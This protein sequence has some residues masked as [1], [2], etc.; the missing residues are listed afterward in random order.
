[1]TQEPASELERLVRIR[2]LPAEPVVIEADA[3]ERERLAARFGILGVQ[4]LTAHVALHPD[5]AGVRASGQLDAVIEQECAVSGEPFTTG[6]AE[7]IDLVFVPDTGAAPVSSEEEIELDADALDEITFTGD[8]FDLG[9]AVAQTL[10]LAID[11]YAEGPD[12]DAARARAGIMP[13]DAPSGPLAA[14]LARLKLER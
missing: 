3:Q 5:G 8:S 2:H 1:M 9:E 6:L 7:A 10:G 12:A 14:A 11:P 4:T 13:D